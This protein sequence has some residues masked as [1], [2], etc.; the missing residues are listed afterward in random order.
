MIS[1]LHID[2]NQ[3]LTDTQLIEWLFGCGGPVI[4]YRTAREL[5]ENRE[6]VDF[7]Q[8]A[9]DLIDSHLVGVWLERL[10]VGST[11]FVDL[12]SSKATAY[13]NVMGKLIQLGCHR[14]IKPFDRKTQPFYTWL[15]SNESPNL[16]DWTSFKRKVVGS[17]L[18]A[19]GYH[20]VAAVRGFLADRL[21]TL[22]RFTREMNF[23]IYAD[24]SQ[25]SG[26][27]KGF[28]D[29]PLV[30]PKLYKDGEEFLPSIYDIVALASYP[31]DLLSTNTMRKI[32]S[33]IEY[34]LHPKYQA[35]PEGYG[36]MK[37]GKRKY[38]AMGWSVHL[39]GYHP[40]RE[41][42]PGDNLL[43]QRLVLMS[44]F[45]SATNHPWFQRSIRNL[46]SYHTNRGTYIFPR[47]YLNERISGYWVT[48][49]Y[50]GLE[51]NRRKKI[52]LELESTFWM[53]KIKKNAGLLD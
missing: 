1:Y 5:F 3:I 42:R 2:G 48:G 16:L 52:A 18:V 49:A 22:W 44:N 15:G 21:D 51:E 50:M 33:V 14:G 9:G 25:Y 26:I 53:L 34:I 13:E 27:P 28:H 46:E 38:Y 29:K 17:F 20:H 39:P 4:R 6:G 8:L 30:K 37:A 36:L 11:E 35:F 24:R 7:G 47:A 10:S 23:D 32:D 31:N 40:V 45:P 12:H 43:I 41:K 19:A